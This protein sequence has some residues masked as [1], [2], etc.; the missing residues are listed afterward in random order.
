MRNL[1]KAAD[2][3]EELRR[4]TCDCFVNRLER[5]DPLSDVCKRIYK[6]LYYGGDWPAEAQNSDKALDLLLLAQKAAQKEKP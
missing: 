3:L 6:A 4:L 1:A 2:L 5:R